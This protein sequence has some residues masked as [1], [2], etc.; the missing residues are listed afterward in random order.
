MVKARGI[1]PTGFKRGRSTKTG[2][3]ISGLAYLISRKILKRGIKSTSFFQRPLQIGIARFGVGILN[4]VK[5]DFVT[6]FST[7]FKTK[8]N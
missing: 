7:E 2:Q 1:K 8:I 3:Y 4:A 5:E 6:M